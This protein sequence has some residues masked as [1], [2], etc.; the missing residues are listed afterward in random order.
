MKKNVLARNA[1]IAFAALVVTLP[2][3]FTSGIIR[4]AEANQAFDLSLGITPDAGLGLDI[5]L[6]E[7]MGAAIMHVSDVPRLWQ[8]WEPQEKIKAA[9]ANEAERREMTWQRYGWADRPEGDPWIPMGYTPDGR[10]GLVTNCFACHGGHVTGDTIMGL[11]NSHFDL[12]TLVT[13]V[14]KLDALDAGRDP[15]SVGDMKAPFNTPFNFQKG[16]SNAV[17]FAAVFEALRNPMLAQDYMQHPEKLRHHDMNTPAWWLFKKK[18]RL[19]CDAFAPKT[20]RQIMP[21]AMSPIFSD[22]KFRS[23]EPNFVHIQA[24]L[25]QLEAPKYPHAIDDALAEKGRLAFNKNCMKCHGR[26]D[27]E[28]GYPNKVVPIEEVGTDPIRLTAI[29]RQLREFSN[30]GWLQYFGEH[31]VDVEPEGYIAPPLDGIWAT[32]PYLHN[33]SIPTLYHLFNIDERPVIWRR[34][35]YGYDWER[36]GI[37]VME[38]KQIPAGLNSRERRMFYNTGRIGNSAA[39]HPFP[40]DYLSDDEKI[41]VMEYLKTL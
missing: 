39:G 8:V 6:N 19:Y 36:G 3:I 11:G 23:F 31:P 40:D 41:A 14:L 25:E 7:P 37:L 27:D 34:N 38:F 10:G 20:P 1:V 18:E 9:D 29:P 30:K 35:D 2:S 15:G 4:A 16:G 24:Y 21:F 22:E 32:A 17:I 13:D 28:P 26:Y 12:T 5:I 33:G